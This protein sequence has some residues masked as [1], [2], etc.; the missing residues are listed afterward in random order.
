MAWASGRVEGRERDLIV[1]AARAHGVE[2]GSAADRQL[3]GWLTTRP[4]DALFVRTL[5]LIAAIL[6]VRP[7][8]E[9]EAAQR[10]LLSYC[11]AIASAAGGIL[12]F[13]A[14]SED[15]RQVLAR[16]TREL[17]MR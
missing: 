17:E 12:G 7:A 11:T 8:A 9:R 4:S 13:G 2:E 15:E 10:D 6:Q 16:I 3:E 1:Q 14:V 5:H